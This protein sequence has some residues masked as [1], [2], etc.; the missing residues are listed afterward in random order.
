ME[1]LAVVALITLLSM[2]DGWSGGPG[3][4][5]HWGHYVSEHCW[6]P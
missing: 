5:F 3:E 1:V 4:M 6:F 2:V